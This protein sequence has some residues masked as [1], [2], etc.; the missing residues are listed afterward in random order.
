MALNNNVTIVPMPQLRVA[1]F[2]NDSLQPMPLVPLHVT[3]MENCFSIH[4]ASYV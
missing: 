3:N 1:P 4:I 2:V